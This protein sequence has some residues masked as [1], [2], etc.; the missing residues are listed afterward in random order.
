MIMFL[1]GLVCLVAALFVGGIV[2]V[3][4]A[5]AEPLSMLAAVLF[6]PAIWWLAGIWQRSSDKKKVARGIRPTSLPTTSRSA[7]SSLDDPLDGLR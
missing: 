6:F 1:F 2:L 4:F 7:S 3:G 5:I